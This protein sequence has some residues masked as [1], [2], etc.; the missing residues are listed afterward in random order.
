MHCPQCGRELSAP[1]AACLG[2]LVDSSGTAAPPPLNIVYPQAAPPPPPPPPAVAPPPPP[3]PPAVA[4][5]PPPPY[6]PAG[7]PTVGQPVTQY[8]A[9]YPA[10]AGYQPTTA[11]QPAGYEPSY[12]ASAPPPAAGR[13][14]AVVLAIAAVAVLVI[15]GGAVLLTR[16]ND[17]KQSTTSAAPTVP[18]ATPAPIVPGSTTAPVV[19]NPQETFPLPTQPPTTLAPVTI[20]PTA[21][22][23]TVFDPAATPPVPAVTPLGGPGSPQVLSNPLPSG[24]TYDQVASSLGIAQQ[25][26]D[27]L[28]NDD[29]DT[30]RRL[31]PAKSGNSNQ[32]YLAGYD[33]LDRVSLLLVDAR[34]EGAG[35]RLLVVSVANE[36]AG[37]RT[38]LYCLEWT[39]D[40]GAVTVAQHSGVVGQ[41]ARVPYAISPEGVRNDP[42]LDATVRTQCH[43]N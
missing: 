24:L 9:Q 39:V 27:A 1:G 25:L 6:E 19:S 23:T 11:Y 16:G 8:P 29:W 21:P 26:G 10:N 37:A 15:A 41:I 3:P 17:D 31:E 32:K 20:P 40:P 33:G 12:Q 28:A 36:K 5:P 42:S 14:T 22:P 2:C 30:A 18:H 38:S 4:P 35:Y 13:R 43:W 7:Q 34:P